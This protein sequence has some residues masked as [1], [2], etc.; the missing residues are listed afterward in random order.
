MTGMAAPQGSATAPPERRKRRTLRSR[1]K[2]SLYTV[3]R[4]TVRVLA[5]FLIG[6]RVRGRGNLPAHGP[7]I[8]VSN[9]LHNF[10]MIVIGAALTRPVFYMG[11][12]ELFANR[13][14]GPFF[15][16][17]G[18]FPVNREAID[19][20]ALRHAG[21]LLDEGLVVGILPEGTRSTTR[22][23]TT[24]NPGVALIAYQ[25][26]VPILPV[27]ITGTQHLPFDAKATGERWFGRRVT[28]TIGRPFTLPARQ[29]GVRPDLDAA[30]EQIMLAIAA[31]L[32]PDYRGVY[33]DRQPGE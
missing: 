21:L 29:P 2:W 10:D 17:M 9:H 27:A 25:R 11:K 32:P 31:L 6:L 26:G 4:I 24:G 12:R 8:L 30:T 28:V 14:A 20:A 23:L 22:Q 18:A 19:R 16:S 3:V 1:V 13:F 15:R 5:Y 33:A 7:I